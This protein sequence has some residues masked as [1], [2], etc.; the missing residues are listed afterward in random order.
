MTQL[1]IK[2]AY[3]I[4]MNDERDVYENGN[5]LIED[6]IIKAV[7]K[8]DNSIVDKNAEIYDANG[9]ILMPGLINTHVHLSQ[10]L[11]RGIADDV[12]LLTWLRDRVWPYESSFDYND[13][14][15]S[16][17][18]CCIELIRSGVTTFLE[19]GGQYVDAMVEAVDK[20]GIRAC[21]AKSVMDQGEG[22]P[23]AWQKT[24]EEELKTQIDLFEKY[25]NTSNE[26]VKIWFALRTIF[27]NSDELIVKTKELADKYN[28]GIHMHIA[29]IADEV[30]FAKTRNGL[31][32]VE[33]LNSLGALGPNLLAVHTVWLTNREIDLFRLNNVKVSHNPA[34]AMKVVLGFASIPEMLDKGIP[35]SIGT[36]GAPSNNRMDM[37]RDMYLTS[38]IHKG[39]TLNPTV[40]NAE[41]ILEMATINGAKCAL[42]NKEIGSLE[43]GKKA[44]MIILNPNTIH[45]LPMH[46]PIGNIVYAMS[47]EN[48]ESTICDGKWLMKEKKILVLDESKLLEKIKEQAKK[49][50]EKS[51][52][53]L[54]SNFNIIK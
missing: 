47:S 16:S 52:I 38:L 15:I 33:H 6:N 24:C 18:A 10:Q 7:G 40:V 43:V 29:E 32:T 28:T 11:G 35:V 48:I 25:N 4:T 49:I 53:K 36:D 19:S 23:E 54:N 42:L 2:N 5:I 21:L 8:F 34:A 50:R 41:K 37:M 30:D 17:T 1:L 22:L 39:R 13:S 46:N 51:N 44:D 26:R 3:L 31:P 9:K 45:S 27:N 14:L 12:D 20:T